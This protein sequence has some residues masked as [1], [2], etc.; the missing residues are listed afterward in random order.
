MNRTTLRWLG[1]VVALL[2]GTL[3]VVNRESSDEFAHS[4]DALL[5]QLRASVNDVSNISVQRAG[6][7]PVQI[8]KQADG[9]VV[10]ARNDYPA[11]MAKVREVLLAMTEAKVV[12]AK[13][14]KAE[15][16]DKLGLES[17]DADGSKGILVSTSGG[18][19]NFAVIFGNVAQGDYRY[20]RLAGEAQ[21]WLIDQ[22]PDIPA[23]A[24]D[25]LR[26]DIIDIDSSR[27]RSVTITHPDG[28]RIHAFKAAQSDSNFQVADIPAG[29][30]LSYSTV[31][32]GLAGA[33]NDLELDDV[34][35][36]VA[37]E[38]AI[39]TEFETFDG[40][41]IRAHTLKSDA[42]SWLALTAVD[43]DPAENA[44]DESDDSNSDGGQD[45][46]DASNSE[47]SAAD[48]NHRLGAWQ[49][50]IA[51]YKANLLGRR[52]DDILKAQAE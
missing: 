23:T 11:D 42:G 17:P 43:I 29:R 31:A 15:L 12:E 49:Y 32:N 48:I 26:P 30:E 3:L 38:G 41:S 10:S 50:R 13:T 2:V 8:T 35:A 46:S 34:R 21:T 6:S 45:A 52:W 7:D 18:E 9:W 47:A 36:A 24:A 22:N 14:A 16:H 51:D 33:L 44:G 28:E 20:A 39:V 25:W 5:P 40:L 27:V 19:Q 37:L 4:G 1:I